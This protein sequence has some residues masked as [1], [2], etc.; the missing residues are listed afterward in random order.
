VARFPGGSEGG[1]GR[2]CP[3]LTIPPTRVGGRARRDANRTAR[4]V[5]RGRTRHHALG[6]GRA[7]HRPRTLKDGDLITASWAGS[8]DD[9]EASLAVALAEPWEI[10]GIPVI[11]VLAKLRDETSAVIDRFRPHP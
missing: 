2:G 6:E 3:S 11:E 10:Q 8:D 7:R 1:R 9:T 4:R 5:P